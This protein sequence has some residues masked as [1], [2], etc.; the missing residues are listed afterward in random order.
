MLSTENKVF[1]KIIFKYLLHSL[2][3]C[4]N[5]LS[6]I[7][8]FKLKSIKKKKKNQ[9]ITVLF[10]RVRKNSVYYFFKRSEY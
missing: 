3:F 1:L 7:V 10:S 6:I 9:T 5:S 8:I 4:C 2:I